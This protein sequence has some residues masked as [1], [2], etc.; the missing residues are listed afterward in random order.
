MNE[1][2]QRY[3]AHHGILGQKWGRHQGPPY[4]LGAS[5]HSALEKKEGY[6]KSLGG[7]RNEKLYDRNEKSDDKPKTSKRDMR[8]KA[9]AYQ[10]NMNQLQLNENNILLKG[11][12]LSDSKAFADKKVSDLK[13]KGA[14][15]EKINEWMQQSKI[16][17]K[18]IKDVVEDLK[19]N[20]ALIDELDKH[21]QSDSDIVYRTYANSTVSGNKQYRDYSNLLTDKY[22]KTTARGG[23]GG[24]HS[25]T[26]TRYKVRAGTDRNKQKKKYTDPNYKRRQDH[27][28]TSTYY[29]MY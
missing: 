25:V 22:G 13:K 9:K 6:K 26:G 7:G 8:K 4:P 14:D 27:K 11:W 21:M 18:K 15:K 19:L 29:Y 28:Y 12:D 2:E 1:L 10:K 5:D 16:L 17:D 23:D 20:R 24:Q 3:L